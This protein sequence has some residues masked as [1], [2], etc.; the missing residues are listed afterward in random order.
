MVMSWSGSSGGLKQLRHAL[1]AAAREAKANPRVL[2]GLA[3]I[4]L[5]VWNYGLI[6]LL[7]SVAASE[8]RLLDIETEIRRVTQIAGETGWEQ[9]ALQANALKDRLIGRL[10]T[11]ETEGQAQADFQE[12]V[13][14]AARESGLSRPQIRVDRDPTQNPA[15][16]VRVISASVG[17]DFAPEPLSAFLIKLAALDR[18]IQ[19]RT[20]R[21]TR[22][23]IAR[24]D[25]LVT[26]YHGPATH[27]ACTAPPPVSATAG[28]L[29]QPPAKSATTR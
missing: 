25:M 2:I 23:P 27:A 13:A 29:A 16:G 1:D 9:R 28:P 24:L 19:V 7:D 18:V 8:R 11:G 6:T 5:L 12:A 22:Q 21:T 10:W 15:L 14:R 17:A 3:A 4:L 26:A 20:L